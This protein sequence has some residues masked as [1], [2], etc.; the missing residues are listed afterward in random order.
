MIYDLLNTLTF[1]GMPYYK[2][3]VNLQKNCLVGFM[4]FDCDIC[5]VI[6]V[7]LTTAV[8]NQFERLLLGGKRKKNLFFYFF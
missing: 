5:D 8:R 4:R 2:R 7:A 6:D 1:E 3:Y